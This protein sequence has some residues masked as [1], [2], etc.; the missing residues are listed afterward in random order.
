MKHLTALEL[1]LKITDHLSIAP[2]IL[3]CE[4]CGRVALAYAAELLIDC[5]RTKE[6]TAQ[7]H[8]ADDNARFKMGHAFNAS[9]DP[10]D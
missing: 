9:R 2:N 10:Q 4:K 1:G 8:T 7:E 5:Q 3:D 6:E